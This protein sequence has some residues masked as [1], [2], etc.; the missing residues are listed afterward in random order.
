M[1]RSSLFAGL[2]CA[3]GAIAPASAEVAP[4]GCDAAAGQICY[5]RIYYAKGIARAVQMTAGTKT[6]VPDVDIGVA[7]YCASVGKP[8]PPKCSQKKINTNHNN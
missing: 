8:P 7:T 3:L 2:I 4:F 6:T 1:R 5:F